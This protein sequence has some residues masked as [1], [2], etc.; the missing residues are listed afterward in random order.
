MICDGARPF[1]RLLILTLLLA[2][3]LIFGGPARAGLR[4]AGA[5]YPDVTLT[6]YASGFVEPTDIASTGVPGDERLFVVEKDGIIQ[7]VEAGGLVLG[8]PFL[9]IDALAA[10]HEQGLLGLAFHP[11]YANNG[12]FYVNYT[13]TAGPTIPDFPW[14][15][16]ISRFSV[17]PLNPN[18]ADPA[19]EVV[20]LRFGQPYSN[21]NGGDLAFGPDGYLYIATGDGGSGGDP[22]NRAQDLGTLLGKILRIDVDGPPPYSVPSSNPYNDGNP[23]TLPEIW[24]S[25]L[26]NPWRVSFDQATGDLL[27]SDVGQ[28]AREEVNLQVAESAGGENFGWRCYEGNLPFKPSGCGPSSQYVFPIYEYDHSAG[29]AITGGFV[30]RGPSSPQ[31]AGSYLFADHCSGNFWVLNPK[32]DNSWEAISLGA[33]AGEEISTF[34]ENTADEIYVAGFSS[35]KI[36]RIQ[37]NTP[38]GFRSFLPLFRN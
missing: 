23:A 4:N 28:N 20:V 31:L 22:E 26:R 11:D 24:A 12:Y 37:E 9:Q 18:L 15:S 16:R 6:E 10:G 35:G 25:G 38:A 17:D 1:K 21:H 2:A 13:Y 3:I 29:C 33:L 14:E 8:T 27:I 19:S 36:Y 34:G 30:Y 5:G 32:A 7:V